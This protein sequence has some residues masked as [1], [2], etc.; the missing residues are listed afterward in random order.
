MELSAVNIRHGH[1]EVPARAYG[2]TASI[3]VGKKSLKFTSKVRLRKKSWKWSGYVFQLQFHKKNVKNWK[4]RENTTVFE[5]QSRLTFQVSFCCIWNSFFPPS[6]DF[7]DPYGAKN[8]VCKDDLSGFIWHFG[9]SLSLSKHCWQ[10]LTGITLYSQ[11][12]K[13]LQIK[14]LC[15]F[16]Q[17]K[18]RLWWNFLDKKGRKCSTQ[19]SN[20]LF[21]YNI[22]IGF[23]TFWWENHL[24]ISL[25]S[26]NAIF[27][28]NLGL[29]LHLPS[30]LQ[31]R[32]VSQT[33]FGWKLSILFM[34]CS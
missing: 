17:C 34:R 21:P 26:Q 30:M 31:V 15:V 27:S 33:T 9:F 32:K 8:T 18:Q 5:K 1:P 4:S 23:Q 12:S 13:K 10:K 25:F 19:W 3:K 29:A 28:P 24:K 7:Y 2:A 14:Q 11:K 6:N 16:F 20:P 22:I